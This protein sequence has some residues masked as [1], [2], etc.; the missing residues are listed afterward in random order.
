MIDAVVYDAG[1]LIALTGREK[2]AQADH[3]AIIRRV[4]PIVPGP[5]LAQVWR[6]SP[7]TRYIVSRYLNDCV[8]YTDYTIQDYKRAGVML[9]DAVLAA[10]KHPDVVDALVALTAAKHGNTAILTSDPH[11]IR[12]Y[13]ATLPEAGIVVVPI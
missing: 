8:T 6:D 12:A 13:T 10:K 1:M 4:R 5:V 3:T 11:D 2:K 7:P 9:G